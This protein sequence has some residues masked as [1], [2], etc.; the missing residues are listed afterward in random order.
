MGR[1]GE[2]DQCVSSAVVSVKENYYDSNSSLVLVLPYKTAEYLNSRDFLE[3]YYND[4]EICY[5]SSIA[6][7][8][9]AIEIRNKYMI[10]QADLVICYVEDNHGG[11][12]KV[13]QYAIKKSKP[14]LNLAP[15]SERTVLTVLFLF[16]QKN[17]CNN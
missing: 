5:K 16:R 8:K 13:M 6:F 10:D 4:I 15:K 3:D 1:N 2:F 14:V 17:I 12:Y 9:S 7:P 11:A